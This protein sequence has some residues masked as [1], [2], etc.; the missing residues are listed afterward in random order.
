V[1]L[2]Q[3]ISASPDVVFQEIEGESVLL[4]LNDGKYFG[5]DQVGTRIWQL[6]IEQGNLSAV[7]EQMLTEYDVTPEKLQ[8]DLE[9]LVRELVE[10]DLLRLQGAEPGQDFE[11]G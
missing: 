5:L 2:K 4:H 3:E 10:K 6:V 7:F 9:K 1:N 8:A 11:Q